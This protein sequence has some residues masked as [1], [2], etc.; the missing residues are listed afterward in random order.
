MED[1]K[2]NPKHVKIAPANKTYKYTA[3][4]VKAASKAGYRHIGGYSI[5]CKNCGHPSSVRKFI[6]D[7]KIVY[8][9]LKCGMFN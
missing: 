2:C 9:C 6:R 7:N 3:D 5:R 4:L 8:K 1:K